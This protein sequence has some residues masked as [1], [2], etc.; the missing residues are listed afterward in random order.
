MQEGEASN[1]AAATVN[2]LGTQ[3]DARAGRLV[4]TMPSTQRF[5]M[6]KAKSDRLQIKT[7][8]DLASKGKSLKLGGPSD[9]ETNPFCIPGLKSVYNLDFSSAFT[10]MTTSAVPGSLDN[11][12]VDVGI[13]FTTDG[14]PRLTSTCCSRTTRGCSAPTTSSL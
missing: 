7:L 6:T 4:V 11:N 8:S 5:A 10:S 14:V 1:D 3:L 2:K 9:C 13:I 12:E